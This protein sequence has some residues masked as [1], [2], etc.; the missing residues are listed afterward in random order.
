MPKTI[1]LRN[2]VQYIVSIDN[3]QT[4][5]RKTTEE[6]I[7][8][9]IGYEAY[10]LRF[11]ETYGSI[12]KRKNRAL[13][14][15]MSTLGTARVIGAY[16]YYKN[17]T[18]AKYQI[19]AYSTFLKV[20]NDSS[21]AFTNIKTGL[22]ADL[23]FTW[24]TY[25]DLCYAFNGI[26][27][28]S[29]FDGTNCESMGVPTPTAPSGT[30]TA[31]AGNPNGT[32]Y[33]KVSYQ[34]DGYQEG[35]ASIASAVVVTGG[36]FKITVTIPVSTNTRVTARILYRT[37]ASGAI[38]YYC[39]TISDNTSTTYTDNIAD[40]SLDTTIT[41]PTDYG[42]PASY[43]LSCLHKSRVFL[44]RNATYKSRIIFSDIRSGIAY[45]DV[46]P[47]NNYFDILKDNGE[48]LTFIGEDNFG[49]L[50]AMKP[51]AL[52]KINTDTDDPIG[53][54]G[55]NSVIS[56]NGNIAPYSAVKTLIGIIYLSRFAE[57]RKRLMVWDGSKTQPIFEELEPVLSAIL[58]NRLND[59]V[60]HY[61]D[62]CYMMAYNDSSEETIINNRILIINLLTGSWVIDKKNVDCFT[63]WNGGDDWGEL[64]TGVSDTTGFLYREDTDVSTYQD[65]IIK[66]KSEFDAGS[67]SQCETGGTETS[68]T[69]ILIEA[70]LTDD[71]GAKIV[72]T[73]DGTVSDLIS[74]ENNQ[75]V[76]PSCTYKSPVY[77][78]NAKELQYIYWNEVIGTG[79]YVRFWVR[80]GA[81]SAACQAA[82]WS[83]PY[84]TYSGSN[85]S[86]VTAAK[87]IQFMC[88]LYVMNTTDAAGTYLQRVG[89]NDYVVKISFG[90]GNPSEADIEIEYI[91]QWLD[92]GWVHASLKRL[93]KRI[94]AIKI[95]FERTAASGT[96]TFGYYLDGSSTRTDINF[97]F[98]TYASRGYITYQFPLGI[99]C[100]RFKYRLYNNDIG[101]LKIK[102]IIFTLSPEPYY[103]N[104]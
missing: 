47:A 79:G 89:G 57:M 26:D 70:Q 27:N 65:K 23:R 24:L 61:H 21:G 62:G 19:V 46:F 49:Q 72:S 35:N 86:A 77:E 69:L 29:V 84:A 22:S 91:S 33:Y 25:K 101:I 99:Y 1:A 93:R 4:L 63:S 2:A 102:K 48:E 16:R 5:A 103:P 17:S 67:F 88:K 55:M 51:S 12:V 76:A 41:A 50:I 44:A 95:E 43:K 59:I 37:A 53:W 45:P 13:Y 15:G 42:T 75:T 54:S 8:P 71:W 92:F 32:Y 74:L 73:M 6:L 10:N 36:A 40:A 14:G 31:E 85:I 9:T 100:T 60:G 39:A 58:D 104:L 7:K 34:I 38:Y 66:L 90:Y 83:G 52:V 94:R 64:Y 97:N 56:S 98:S 96:L 18:D 80:T 11:D 87:Y 28:N 68:P 81:S 78:V 20:G 3:F 82:E 30:V